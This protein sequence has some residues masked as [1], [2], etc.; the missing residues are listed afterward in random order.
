MKDKVLVVIIS[1]LLCACTTREDATKNYEKSIGFSQPS[2]TALPL[3]ASYAEKRGFDDFNNDGIQDMIEIE[4]TVVIGRK[5]EARVFFGYYEKGILNFQNKIN[6]I[7]LPIK[8]R[9]LTDATK[10]DLGDVNGDGYCDIIITQYTA[11]FRK[12][13]IDIAFAINQEGNSF[14]FQTENLSFDNGNTVADTILMF[15]EAM[16]GENVETLSDYLKMD[17]DDADG[18]GSDDLHLFWDG[19]HDLSVEIIYTENTK[20]G[21]ARFSNRV[22]DFII[23]EFMRGRS[24][25]E[26]DIEDFNN[27]NRADIFLHGYILGTGKNSISIAINDGGKGFIPHKDFLATDVDMKFFKFEK[28]D[29]F[30]VNND[31]KADFVHLGEIGNEKTM[32]YNINMLE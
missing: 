6:T 18:N 1:L 24:I 20:G 28:Y 32:A 14:S 9:W 2:T 17:W 26:I 19:H 22:S 25:R 15:I 11:G 5:Y 10:F 12:D 13:R 8:F 31:G 23:P 29:T 30:D 21:N 27:D 7:R 3:K 16:D 4:D